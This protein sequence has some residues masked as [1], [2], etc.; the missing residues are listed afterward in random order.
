MIV[1]RA[2]SYRPFA[3][4][5]A[6]PARALACLL[7]VSLLVRSLI[8]IGFMPVSLSSG[9][10]VV[11]CPTANPALAEWLRSAGAAP[12]GEGQSHHPHDH[13][14]DDAGQG[15]AGVG[16]LASTLASCAF[17]GW[18]AALFLPSFPAAMALP[19]YRAVPPPVAE[20]HHVL[21]LPHSRPPARGPPRF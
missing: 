15:D 21:H 5:P 7:L 6:R 4:G 14:A 20:A 1:G 19:A 3:P 13:A 2:H 9:V 16:T 18:L 12:H 10:P 17:A 8:P 11:L